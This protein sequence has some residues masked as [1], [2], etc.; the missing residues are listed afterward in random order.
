MKIVLPLIMV[1]ALAASGCSN[2]H[3]RKSAEKKYAAKLFNGCATGDGVSCYKLAMA[4]ET[5]KVGAHIYK[6]QPNIN[7]SD[8][9]QTAITYLK[10]ECAASKSESCRVVGDIYQNLG[11]MGSGKGGKKV[12]Y[13]SHAERI[14]AQTGKHNVA[15]WFLSKGYK[16]DRKIAAEYYKKACHLSDASSCKDLGTAL[17]N[18]PVEDLKASQ[19]AYA[20]AVE[21]YQSDCAAGTKRH[22]SCDKA[23]HILVY[24][25]KTPQSIQRGLELYKEGCKESY[26]RYCFNVGSIYKNDRFNLKNM[27]EAKKYFQKACDFEKRKNCSMIHKLER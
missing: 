1:F 16:K 8:V 27:S 15:S 21:L 24:N 2:K 18:P 10:S 4:A 14:N 11:Y 25:M 3:N 5:I 6:S 23:P 7:V 26:P 19:N 20:K 13:P 22:L 17:S 9:Y 12:Y